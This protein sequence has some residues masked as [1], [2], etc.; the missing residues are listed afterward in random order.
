MTNLKVLAAFGWEVLSQLALAGVD[1][2]RKRWS[3]RRRGA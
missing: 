2:A 3:A 1:C